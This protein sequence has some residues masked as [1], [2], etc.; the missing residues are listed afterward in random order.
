MEQTTF[1]AF[2]AGDELTFN[3]IA[4]SSKSQ[5]DILQNANVDKNLA[6]RP[7]KFKI[8]ATDDENI[9]AYAEDSTTTNVVAPVTLNS[10]HV[11]GHTSATE[12]D[13][14][15]TK[16]TTTLEYNADNT[17]I[18]HYVDQFNT[19]YT[20]SYSTEGTNLSDGITKQF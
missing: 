13:S 16:I 11:M 6:D 1:A 2:V 10:K 7:Y 15:L 5:Y 18:Y 14:I 12:Y 4:V 17:S 19:T 3:V 8:V 9:E 20:N